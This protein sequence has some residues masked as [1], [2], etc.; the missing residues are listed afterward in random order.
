MRRLADTLERSTWDTFWVPDDVRVIDRSDALVLSCDRPWPHLNIV[1]RTR[2]P[3]SDLDGLVAEV[4]AL[5][6]TVSCWFVPT[7][8]DATGLLARLEVAGYRPGYD[9][10]ARVLAV[11]SAEV[12]RSPFRVA[13]VS[14]AAGLDDFYTP[15]C[16]AFPKATRPSPE[17][18]AQ[19]LAICTGPAARVRRFV[20]YEGERPV[21]SGAITLHP[22][23]RF[24]LFWGGGTAPEAR[25]RGAYTALVAARL[26]AARRSGIEHVGLYARADTSAPIV[27]KQ[28]FEKVGEMR[29]WTWPPE[30]A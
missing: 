7:T 5:H 2:A 16:L 21:A 12:R 28:G 10:E 27:A 24:G 20:A 17:L 18:L 26:L 11:E 25:G 22:A 8:F 19:E 1:M 29:F 3:D 23:L 15:T 9:Y 13:V 6:P 30:V 14:D 4:R